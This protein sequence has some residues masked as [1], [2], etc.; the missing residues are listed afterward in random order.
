VAQLVDAVEN[1]LVARS[2]EIERVDREVQER[3]SGHLLRA[4]DIVFGR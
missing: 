2:V 4:G 3:L 1:S